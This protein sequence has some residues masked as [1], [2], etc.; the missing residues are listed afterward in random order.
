MFLF[1]LLAIC[2]L[3]FAVAPARGEDPNSKLELKLSL[4]KSEIVQLEPIALIISVQ[5]LANE[6]QDIYPIFDRHYQHL[7]VYVTSPSGNENE[8][9]LGGV[10]DGWIPPYPL[11]KKGVIRYRMMLSGQPKGWMDTPGEYKLHITFLCLKNP[12]LLKS[13]PVKLTVKPAEGVDK[14]ALDRFRGYPQA[15]FLERGTRADAIAEQ[16]RFVIRKYPKSVYTPWCY[17]ILGWAAQNDSVSAP[18]AKAVNAIGYY[19]RLLKEYPKFP[20]KTEVEYEMARE[21]LWLGKDDEAAIDQIEDLASKHS[22]L[23]LFRRVNMK[24]K[25]YRDKGREIPDDDWPMHWGG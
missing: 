18:S 9:R 17:Y 4:S 25:Y 13:K 3:G 15:D 23:W 11:A 1:R 7:K 21:S 24:L 14:E 6:A 19:E 16:F 22:D 5:N 8:L 10:A 20:M 2:A 12:K